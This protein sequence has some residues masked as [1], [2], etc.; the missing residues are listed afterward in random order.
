[1]KYGVLGDVHSN[2]SAVTAAIE[3][4]DRRGVDAIVSVTAPSA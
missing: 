1:M 2:L 4:L 3:E